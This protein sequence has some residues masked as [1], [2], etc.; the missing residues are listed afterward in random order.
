MSMQSR[1]PI[2]MPALK[3]PIG[4]S[5]MFTAPANIDISYAMSNSFAFGGSSAS[6]IVKRYTEEQ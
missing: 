5:E 2:V 3:E 1:R 6:L 4:G